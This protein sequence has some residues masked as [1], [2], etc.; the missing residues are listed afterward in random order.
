V[1]L[2]EPVHFRTKRAFIQQRISKQAK[3][4]GQTGILSYHLHWLV[5]HHEDDEFIVHNA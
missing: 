4:N 1:K 2:V 5:V 3:A